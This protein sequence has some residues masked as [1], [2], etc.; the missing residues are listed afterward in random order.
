MPSICDL[1][2]DF[3]DR[4]AV[5]DPQAR[6]QVAGA[7]PWCE[8]VD[9]Q[10]ALVDGADVVLCAFQLVDY[11]RYKDCLQRNARRLHSCG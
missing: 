5:A 6:R 8:V 11:R 9:D 3:P 4:V 7:L 2:D 1:C 10:T